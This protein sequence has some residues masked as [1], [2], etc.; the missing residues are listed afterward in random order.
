MQEGVYCLRKMKIVLCGTN[1]PELDGYASI[2]GS[3]CER[4][5]ISADIKLY[6]NSGDILFD[7]GDI[8]FSA[9]VSMVVVDP[10]NGFEAVPAA[11]REEGY[12][13]LILYLS[14]SHSPDHYRQAFDVDAFQFV[15]KGAD[16]QA[17]SKFDHLFEKSLKAAR[18]VNR[19]YFVANY[20]GE[21]KKIE[22]KNIFY[23]ES[24]PNH[25]VK[26]VYKGGSFTFRVSSLNELEERYYERGFVRSHQSFLVAVGSIHQLDTYDMTLNNSN[27]IPVSRSNY[28]LVKAAMLAY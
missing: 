20:A 8:S 14:H 6:S 27:R 11:I 28:P 19:Q 3:V 21:Y 10:E 7:M 15:A 25:M 23:F 16:P 5:D 2:C 4:L 22:V 17:L 13:G 9:L 18:E 12:D 1:K 26:V 24:L